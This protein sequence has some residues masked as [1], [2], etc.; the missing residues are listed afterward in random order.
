[1][2]K[3]ENTISVDAN[4]STNRRRVGLVA[5]CRVL[6]LANGRR[7]HSLDPALFFLELS[8]RRL[9]AFATDSLS[10]VDTS[11]GGVAGLAGIKRLV[12]AHLVGTIRARALPLRNWT[13]NGTAVVKSSR[14][15]GGG[16]ALLAR[17][18][19]G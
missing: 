15:C 8:Q 6:E 5:T 13:S 10:N 19:A 3:I 11:L 4:R 1:M 12:G 18:I 9:A 7:G 2:E 17:S 16:I 14:L